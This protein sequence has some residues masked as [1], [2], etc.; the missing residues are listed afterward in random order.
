MGP[1]REGA[2]FPERGSG[3][4]RLLI[5][6]GVKGPFPMDVHEYENE[7]FSR[8]GFHRQVCSSCHEAFWSETPRERCAETPCT[9]Y[10]F[11]GSSPFRK[12]YTLDEFRE[13]YLGFFEQRGHARIRRY[14]VVP[15]WRNDVMFVQ[16]SIYDFQPWVTSGAMEPPAN[17]LTISQPC[18][19]FTDIENV[20]VT[21]RH[22]TEFEMMAHHAF[23]RPDHE[24]YFKARTIELCHELLVSELGAPGRE[25]TY[26]EEQWEG[27]GNLGPSVSVG[28]RG[29]EVA[30]LVFM[31]YV[32]D[33][34]HLKP[35]PLTVVDTGYGLE[36]FVW[37]AQGTPTVYEAI[38]PEILAE[39]PSS[40]PLPE[41]AVLLD[42]A[43]SFLFMFTD[44]VVPSNVREGYLARLL[45][46]RMLRILAKRPEDLTLPDLVDRVASR[47]S[48]AFPEIGGNVRGLHEVLSLETERFRE[49]LDRGRQQVRRL[50]ARRTREG[51]TLGVEDLVELY[52]SFGIPPDA[53][54]EELQHPVAVPPDFFA[55]VAAR[56]ESEPPGGGL[57]GDA[58]STARGVPD[59]PPSLPATEVLYYTDPY[60]T[61]FEAKVLWA[62][63]PFLILDRT[64]FY[65]TGGGQITDTGTIRSE[66]VVEVIRKGGWVFHRLEHD[67]AVPLGPGEMVTGI[68]D[69]ARRR[70]LMQH[71][72]ATHLL[73]GALRR[74]LGPH[75]WQAGAYKGPEGARLDVTHYRGITPEELRQVER[76]VNQVVREDRPVRSTFQPRM[77]AEARFGFGLYQ[78][79]AVPG[80]ILR[81]VEIEDFDVEACGGTHCTRTG[82]VGFVKVFSTERIQD[83]M[84]RL[85][86]AAGDRALE[87]VD[88]HEG[89]LRELSQR[90]AAPVDGLPEAI[91]RLEER[92]K[93][94][95]RTARSAGAEDVKEIARTLRGSPEHMR[96][97]SGGTHAAVVA[98]VALGR[99]GL[100]ELAR[101][102]TSDGKGVA[103]LAGEDSSGSAY[104]FFASGDPKRYSAK[105]LLQ[106][107]LEVWRGRG[108]GNDSAATASG[109]GGPDVD[110]ALE[111]AWTRVRD[112]RNP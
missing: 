78:G 81:I 85:H 57:G 59:P 67:P 99:E 47:L 83:G 51:G 25:I 36:R 46:R 94:A 77:E 72:T 9:P 112:G 60:T 75:V 19:R 4:A 52:D 31:E 68:I 16:A 11:V 42:H 10:S 106:A 98:R 80:K 56:H 62:M 23:N 22:L 18:L 50:E 24:V 110:R 63:G 90:L 92:L 40:L 15:R 105:G 41:A 32:R 82:E 107:A 39:L 33:G 102:L 93:A 54:L 103:L 69:A 74:I 27:G 38:F 3:G 61:R 53:V 91:T 84:V 70:Q 2:P 44:G 71:H 87:V 43:R 1:G 48:R 20:G 109:P 65:P 64:Y 111:A 35:M 49:A 55:R 45:L 26:K 73:N 88:Q 30:T 5:R 76:L 100:K 96:T 34:D 108:G 21:G 17:P 95:Q 7:F 29:L 58:D 97:L 89:I 13:F 101:D 12:S 66:P 104:L 14:P 8:K 37:M 86:F 79:G 6:H 28:L